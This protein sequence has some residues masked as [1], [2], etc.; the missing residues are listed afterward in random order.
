MNSNTEPDQRL[1]SPHTLALLMANSR[2]LGK[3][4]D[5]FL[6]YSDSGLAVNSSLAKGFIQIIMPFDLSYLKAW[7]AHFML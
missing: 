2:C 7:F 6:A 1:I 3:E 5:T 4:S